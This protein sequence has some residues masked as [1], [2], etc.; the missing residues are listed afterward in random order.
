MS[1][2]IPLDP[3]PYQIVDTM[4][5]AKVDLLFRMLSLNQAYVT[6]AGKLIGLVTRSSLREYLGKYSKR[7]LDRCTQLARACCLMFSFSQ[8]PS[9]ITRNVSST[10][11]GKDTQR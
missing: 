3:S 10:L 6:H 9:N 8:S 5:L 7:P 2:A 11:T 4:H 1:L